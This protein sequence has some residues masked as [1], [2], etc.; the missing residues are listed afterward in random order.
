MTHSVHRPHTDDFHHSLRHKILLHHLPLLPDGTLVE[1]KLL[2]L[3]NV[4]VDT[5]ALAGSASNESVETTSLELL[6][7]S[8][9]NLA[10]SG[11]SLGLLGL[12]TLA[13]LLLLLLTSLLSATANVGAVV[14]LV[15]LSERSSVDL[16]N[17]GAGQGVGADEFVVRWVEGDGN[18][19]SLAADALGAPG[20]VARVDAQGAE[21]A[22]TTTGANE[23]D[24]LGTNSRVGRL[25][26]L[27]ECSVCQMSEVF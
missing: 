1:S 17:G 9:V 4:T 23:M 16:N 22:V 5:T 21:L 27:L 15:P 25:A 10:T 24:T 11:H 26:T 13:L 3:K 12:D 20:E 14:C 18:D 8:S 7:E 2:T 19:T 6:L